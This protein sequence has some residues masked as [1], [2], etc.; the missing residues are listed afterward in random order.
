MSQEDNKLFDE[1]QELLSKYLWVVNTPPVTGLLI[2]GELW[3]EE[4]TIEMLEYI[5]ET[6]E[7]DPDKLYEKAMEIAKKYPWEDTEVEDE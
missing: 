7:D 2:I 3:E 4:A 6:R 5:A 1:H